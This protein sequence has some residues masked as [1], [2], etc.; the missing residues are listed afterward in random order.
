[1]AISRGGVKILEESY[2]VGDVV[3][4]QAIVIHPMDTGFGK[5]KNS[6]KTMPRYY[7]KEITATFDGKEVGKFELEVSASQNPKVQFPLKITKAGELKVVFTNNL[8]D[9]LVKTIPVTPN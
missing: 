7:I 5:D 9:E 1:M 4:V 6:G 2:K 3:I 8:G